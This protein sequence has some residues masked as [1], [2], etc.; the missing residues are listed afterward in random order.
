MFK[1]AINRIK[2]I[3]E[4][5]AQRWEPEILSCLGSSICD[6]NIIQDV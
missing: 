1:I 3:L 6:P 4:I 2:N 5:Y